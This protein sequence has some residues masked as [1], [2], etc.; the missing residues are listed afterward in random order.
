M[1]TLLNIYYGAHDAYNLI[2]PWIPLHYKAS[3]QSFVARG[4]IIIHTILTDPTKLKSMIPEIVSFVVLIFST[5]WTVSYIIT[6]VRRAIR[7]AWFFLRLGFFVTLFL[8]TLG[9]VYP[10]ESG[11]DL[12]VPGAISSGFHVIVDY[13]DLEALSPMS[14]GKPWEKFGARGGSSSRTRSKSRNASRMSSSR[15]PFGGVSVA[16]AVHWLSVLQGRVGAGNEGEE[17]EGQESTLERKLRQIWEQNKDAWQ[18]ADD[19]LN[20]FKVNTAGHDDAQSN[21]ED[22]AHTRSDGTRSR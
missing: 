20:A 10:D 16:D 2:S 22:S 8:A 17:A 3:V 7:I 6:T 5:Y 12:T 4:W 13:F 19:F 1:D 11:A 9:C 15:S 21:Q 14:P 18:S